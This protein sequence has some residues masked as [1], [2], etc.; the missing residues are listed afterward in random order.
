M[1]MPNP[2]SKYAF[3]S[4]LHSHLLQVFP[5]QFQIN[6]QSK[7]SLPPS[8]SRRRFLSST[9][10]P[11]SSRTNSGNNFSFISNTKK[12]AGDRCIR[13]R[14]WLPRRVR[15]RRWNS[16]GALVLLAEGP[17]RELPQNVF[18]V[19]VVTKRRHDRRRVVCSLNIRCLD[20]LRLVCERASSV[21]PRKPPEIAVFVPVVG[22]LVAS[23][24]GDGTAMVPSS[25]SLKVRSGS[26]PRTSSPSSSSPS[27]ATIV[28]ASSAPSTSAASIFF[29]S[30]ASAHLLLP[31]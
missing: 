4:F 3:P 17:E 11:S 22:C 30:F 24:R 14:C 12:T 8:S 10:V 23:E 19:L 18:A 20:L 31:G 2:S 21:T 13:P 16:H 1:V 29:D 7:P 26:C 9:S 27:A 25:S 28:V 5:L 6:P 15:A